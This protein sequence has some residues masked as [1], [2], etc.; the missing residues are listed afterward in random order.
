MS[1]FSI[2]VVECLIKLIEHCGEGVDDDGSIFLACD[3]IMNI[4]LKVLSSLM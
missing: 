3:T 2:Q 4:L 1:D